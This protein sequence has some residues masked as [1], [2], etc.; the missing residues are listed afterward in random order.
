MSLAFTAMD[1]RE[2]Y[3][4]TKRERERERERNLTEGDRGRG[5]GRGI[6]RGERR[7]SGSC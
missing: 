7:E 4:G 6:K 2:I 3:N 5:R 1:V